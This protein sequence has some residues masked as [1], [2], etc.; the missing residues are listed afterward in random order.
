[1]CSS[2]HPAILAIVSHGP[3]YEAMLDRFLDD[4]GIRE[5]TFGEVHWRE[6]VDAFRRFGKWRHPAALNF[7]DCLTCA[8][9][10]LAGEPLLFVGDGFPETDLDAAQE[11]AERTLLPNDPT[12]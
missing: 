9:A 5:I 3:G 4:F 1:M 10:R 12:E 2:I 7:G 6:A 11:S 8:A